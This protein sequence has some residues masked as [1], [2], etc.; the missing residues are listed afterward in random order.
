MVL[1]LQQSMKWPLNAFLPIPAKLMMKWGYKL[2]TT[3][4]LNN[5]AIDRLLVFCLWFWYYMYDECFFLDPLRVLQQLQLYRG[6]WAVCRAAVRRGRAARQPLAG[7][8]F[9][10]DFGTPK[11]PIFRNP[12]RNLLEQYS[13]KPLSNIGRLRGNHTHLIGYDNVN[14]VISLN[15]YLNFISGGVFIAT[16]VGL[17]IAMIVLA[18]EVYFHK[19]KEN[20]VKDDNHKRWADS[21]EDSLQG[22]RNV[23]K[24]NER[25]IHM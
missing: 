19:K 18:F 3:F 13:E 10:G 12:V 20:S 1:L 16:L 6:W 24:V 5:A 21:R 15:V 14:M 22:R 11:G 25:Q 23:I 9:P 17:G 4:I 8:N 2:Q 7:G